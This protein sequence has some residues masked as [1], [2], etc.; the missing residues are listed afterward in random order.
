[1]QY[2]AQILKATHLLRK[3][4]KQNINKTDIR[5]AFAPVIA[6]LVSVVLTFLPNRRR[7]FIPR[8]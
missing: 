5:A 2:F 1:M 6:G 3:M 4:K 7:L 8:V